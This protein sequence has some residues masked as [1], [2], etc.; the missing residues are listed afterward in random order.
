MALSKQLDRVALCPVSI[1]KL[2]VP[3]LRKGSRP[4]VMAA[5]VA[6]VAATEGA[7]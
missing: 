2:R 6:S 7:P 5:V 4:V 3:A 1:D